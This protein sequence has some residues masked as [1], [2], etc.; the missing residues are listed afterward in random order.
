MCLLS[1]YKSILN[2]FGPRRLEIL[3]P[4]KVKPSG[5]GRVRGDSVH[6]DKHIA[7]VSGKGSLNI[8][9]KYELILESEK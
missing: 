1:K 9:N 2:M 4:R 7:F 3:K 8:S 5:K 6:F